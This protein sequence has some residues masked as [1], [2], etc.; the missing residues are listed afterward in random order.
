MST[1]PSD[2]ATAGPTAPGPGRDRLREL[3]DAVLA[4][5][6]PRLTAMAGKAYSSPWH[7]AGV[8]PRDR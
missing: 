7:F 5:D 4:T 6:E 3:L 8:Q 1:T 2:G